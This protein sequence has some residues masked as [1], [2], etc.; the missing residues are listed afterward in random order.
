MQKWSTLHAIVITVD[1]A[2]DPDGAPNGEISVTVERVVQVICPS[3]GKAQMVLMTP[4]TLRDLEDGT[5]AL[6]ADGRERLFRDRGGHI[7]HHWLDR[8][9]GS[10]DGILHAKPHQ[11]SADHGIGTGC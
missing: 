8:S 4:K 5:Y 7:D 11:W 9:H 3:L 10:F 6:T 1:D 2:T